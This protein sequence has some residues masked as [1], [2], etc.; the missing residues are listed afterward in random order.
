M[1][2]G[3]RSWSHPGHVFTGLS[4]DV[5]CLPVQQVIQERKCDHCGSHTVF[6]NL[7][8]EVIRDHFCYILLVTQ[9]SPGPLHKS[10]NIG[11]LGTLGTVCVKVLI[12]FTGYKSNLWRA[13]SR[14]VS[15]TCYLLLCCIMDQ[16][17]DHPSLSQTLFHYRRH[18]TT[19]SFCPVVILFQ[20]PHFLSMAPGTARVTTALPTCFISF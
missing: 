9:S 4:W 8:L 7:T 13:V 15:V 20:M 5:N 6:Y 14:I 12:V 18:P 19:L 17:Q 11:R 3:R 16:D 1:A 10:V 2:V